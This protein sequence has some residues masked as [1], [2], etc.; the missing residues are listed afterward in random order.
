MRVKTHFRVSSQPQEWSQVVLCVSTPKDVNVEWILPDIMNFIIF[1]N[2]VF[3]PAPF[4]R[5]L[6]YIILKNHP[7]A[8]KMTEDKLI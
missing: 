2:Y 3:L 7:N 5:L 1:L 6:A 4:V 8:R